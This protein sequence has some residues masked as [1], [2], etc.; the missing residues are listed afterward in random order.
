MMAPL[1]PRLAPQRAHSAQLQAMKHALIMLSLLGGF[2]A[3]SATEASAVVCARGVYL[4]GC[5]G[6]NG[7]VG[8]RRAVYAPRHVVVRGG[9]D[10]PQPTARRQL[11]PQRAARTLFQPT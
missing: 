8:V 3:L 1:L 6:P 4:A 11:R 7:A 5:V 2:V 9:G 10:E